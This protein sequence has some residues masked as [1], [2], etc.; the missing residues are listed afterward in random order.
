MRLKVE[1]LP[2]D[3]DAPPVWRWSSK[4]VHPRTTWTASDRHFSAAS[5]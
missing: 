5:A 1:H 3:R 4:P 2:K